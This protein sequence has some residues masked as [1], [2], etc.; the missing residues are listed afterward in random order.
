MQRR[1]TLLGIIAAVMLS[2]CGPTSAPT[3]AEEAPLYDWTVSIKT[4]HL[5]R[6]FKFEGSRLKDKV[7]RLDADIYYRDNEK[8]ANPYESMWYYEGQPLGLELFNKFFI[9]KGQGVCIRIK[10]AT[11]NPTDAEL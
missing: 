4:Q 7:D 10:H 6:Q 1:L 5:E 2:I 8:E 3:Y 9:Q 11:A